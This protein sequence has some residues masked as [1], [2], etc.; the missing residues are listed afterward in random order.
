LEPV[1]EFMG[2]SGNEVRESGRRV[3]RSNWGFIIPHWIRAKRRSD[4]TAFVIAECSCTP[5]VASDTD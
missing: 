1:T 3:R 2:E 5:V 4:L